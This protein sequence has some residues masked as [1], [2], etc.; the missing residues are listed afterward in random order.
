MII[1]VIVIHSF[2]FTGTTWI[3]TL[4]GCHKRAFALGPPDRVMNLCDSERDDAC[5]VHGRNCSFW[6]RF[7]EKHT[8]KENFFLQLA[9]FA[10]KD[11]LIINN[12]IVSGLA[13]KALNSPDILLKHIYVVRDGRA[14]CASYCRHHPEI[15]FY[16]VVKDWFRPSALNLSFDPTSPDI[17]S[18]RY[19]DVVKDQKAFIRDIGQFIGLK[20]P[21]NFYK[22]WEFNHHI[23]AGNAGTIRMISR[24]Q[25]GKQFGSKNRDFYEGEYQKLK[26]QPEKPIVD[27][28]WKDE[29]GERE[30][31]IFDY[32]C[33][34]V[35]E[36]WGY[37]RDRFNVSQMECFKNEIKQ[38]EG[39]LPPPVAEH[40]SGTGKNLKE[41]LNFSTL[42]S[43]GLTLRP[44]HLKVL[45]LSSIS[46]CALSVF[47][48][49]ILIYFLLKI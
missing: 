33:G 5:R 14:V 28:R 8:K 11:F 40:V 38:V 10:N 36:K 42:R 18:V 13:D 24:F 34:T 15:D 47:L 19:E 12:P 37:T 49:A 31:F 29:L 7:F 21:Q 30:L 25:N 3:N 48:L 44:Y 23:T 46:F 27:E 32:F 2:S 9:Q 22:F 1:N 26:E 17:L 16:D 4:L 45:L 41:Q 39:K 35:N 43:E 6:S 20:Y